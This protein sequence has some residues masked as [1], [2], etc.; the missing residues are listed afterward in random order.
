MSSGQDDIPQENC[1]QHRMSR[2]RLKLV[3]QIR[4]TVTV[5]VKQNTHLKK[6]KEVYSQIVKVPVSNLRFFFDGHKIKD[7]DTPDVLAMEENDMIEVVQILDV[8]WQAVR[9]ELANNV[10]YISPAQKPFGSL[11]AVNK[12]TSYTNKVNR[13]QNNPKQS[14]R[15]ANYFGTELT[16]QAKKSRQKHSLKNPLRDFMKKILLRNAFKITNYSK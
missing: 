11:E 9:D 15:E 16:Y 12:F 10:I 2:I 3:S 14:K 6:L 8:G 4:T 1:E 7:K 13:I 5:L